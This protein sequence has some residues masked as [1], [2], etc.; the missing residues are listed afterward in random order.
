MEHHGQHD[1][2]EFFGAILHQHAASFEIEMYVTRRV[3]CLHEA[4]SGD[5]TA[6]LEYL[7]MIVLV[8]L[9][10]ERR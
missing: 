3:F 9:N 5:Y 7:L 2:A 8:L 10:E 1:A 6:R 4:R